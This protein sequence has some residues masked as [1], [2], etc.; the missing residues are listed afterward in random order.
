MFIGN[1]DGDIDI[2]YNAQLGG[3]CSIDIENFANSGDQD[4]HAS[5]ID[6]T[7]VRQVYV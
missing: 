5:C 4:P 1:V 7:E 3:A 2:V 6:D